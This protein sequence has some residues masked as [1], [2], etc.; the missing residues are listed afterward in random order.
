VSLPDP[1]YSA[2]LDEPIV[3][4]VWFAFLDFVGDPVRANTSGRNITPAGFDDPDLDDQ[5][6]IGIS[7][8]LVAVSPVKISEGGSETVTAQLSGIPGLDD[9]VIAMINDSSNWQSRDARLWKIIRN[10]ANVQQGGFD[11]YYT[12]KMVGL[13][14]SG[15]GEGQVLTV[16]IESYLGVF[17][18][19]SNNTYLDQERYDQG[20]ESARAAIA[21]ANGN[22]TGART[23]SGG[24]GG[25]TGPGGRGNVFGG[26]RYDYL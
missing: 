21:I 5:T 10:A 11:A 8:T 22:Y 4:P 13:T 1:T 17:S 12:G 6:F 20:D 14:H 3:K 26:P 9:D 25:G 19:P 24:G 16:T 2:A 7:G 23:G 15:S 18:E